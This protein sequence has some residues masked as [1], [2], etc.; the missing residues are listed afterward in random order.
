MVHE[1]LELFA[2]GDGACAVSGLTDADLG[3]VVVDRPLLGCGRSCISVSIW[4]PARPC[5]S[6]T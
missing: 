6:A 2:N 1:Y 3:K 4:R 5:L